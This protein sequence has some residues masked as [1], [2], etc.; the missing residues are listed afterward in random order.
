MIMDDGRYR[1]GSGDPLVLIHG[2]WESWHSWSAVLDRLSAKRDVLG[3]TLRGHLGAAPFPPGQ[4]PTIEAFADG[5]Q[6]EMDAAGFERPDIAGNSLGGWLALELAK[7][8]RARSVVGIAPA[9]MFTP[10]EGRALAKKFRTDHRMVRLL[11]PVARAAVR[12]NRGRRVLLADN[13]ADPSRI[14]PD[15]AVR[16]VDEFAHANVVRDLAANSRPDGSLTR[17]EDLDSITCPVLILH[18]EHDR[19][20]TRQHAERFVRE[21]PHAELRELPGCGHTAMFDNP[22]LVAS[23]ILNFTASSSTSD[24]GQPTPS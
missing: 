18:P 22:A 20:L 23:E 9:G 3:V 10:E 8:G 6:A 21:L 17:L 14:P 15:E 19:I 12:A 2:V 1:A 13:C 11:R 16:L 7:R 24:R 4:Q 5:V